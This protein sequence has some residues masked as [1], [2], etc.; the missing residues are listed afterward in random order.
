VQ[1]DDV[2]LALRDVELALRD[3]EPALRRRRDN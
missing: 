2:E 1:H 3:V